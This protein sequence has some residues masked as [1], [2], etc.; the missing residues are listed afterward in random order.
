MASARIFNQF[1][2]KCMFSILWSHPFSQ[3]W[4]NDV[5]AKLW[6]IILLSIAVCSNNTGSQR[7]LCWVTF[8]QSSRFWQQ[9]TIIICNLGWV[10]LSSPLALC[11]ALFLCL[12]CQC[13]QE[14]AYALENPEGLGTMFPMCG[15]EADRWMHQ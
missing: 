15:G 9:Y 4:T 3:R 5:G 6:H 14:V 12:L 10:L 7:K 13:H 8:Y 11:K 1:N 2:S